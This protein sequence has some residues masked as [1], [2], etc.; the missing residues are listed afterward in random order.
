MEFGVSDVVLGG[1]DN[2]R[3]CSAYGGGGMYLPNDSEIHNQIVCS[4]FSAAD[5]KLLMCSFRRPIEAFDKYD[6]VCGG[7]TQKVVV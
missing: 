1:S 7:G 2:I 6:Q 3:N 4:L 5:D